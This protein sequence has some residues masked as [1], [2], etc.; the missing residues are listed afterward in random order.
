MASSV[1]IFSNTRDGR[2]H[3]TPVGKVIPK[4]S[5]ATLSHIHEI[6]E[7]IEA[8]ASC[9]KEF[10]ATSTAHG[11]PSSAGVATV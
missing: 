3:P 11:T 1:G 2:R 10:T 6:D 7:S 9:E 4:G 8:M 5:A